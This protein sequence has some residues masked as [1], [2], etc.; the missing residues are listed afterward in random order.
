M[1]MNIGDSVLQLITD[2]PG[3]TREEIEAHLRLTHSQSGDALHRVR[4]AGLIRCV[5]LCRTAAWFEVSVLDRE[6]AKLV[7]GWRKKQQDR[8]KAL[9]ARLWAG[10]QQKIEEARE[11][12]DSKPFV[13]VVVSEWQPVATLPGP[14]SVFELA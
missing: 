1:A 8:R 7:K 11:E 12:E 6:S 2:R 13:H 14:R 9:D 4:A 3:I 5:R 10:R